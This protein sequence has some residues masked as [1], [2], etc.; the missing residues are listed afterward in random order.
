MM[1]SLVRLTH[2]HS[3]SHCSLP[4]FLPSFLY[5]PSFFLSFHFYFS[6]TVVF[7]LFIHSYADNFLILL[8]FLKFYR[9]LCTHPTPHTGHST[10]CRQHSH[11]DYGRWWQESQQSIRQCVAWCSSISLLHPGSATILCRCSYYACVL[12]VCCVAWVVWVR[13]LCV[14]CVCGVVCV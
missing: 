3:H 11:C 5:Y 10:R 13:V 12:C 14:F 6:H 7:S 1:T 9:F 8:L 2:S 4:S